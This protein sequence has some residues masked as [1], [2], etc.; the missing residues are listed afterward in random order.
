MVTIFTPTY[1]RK[2][3][4]KNLYK[5]LLKQTNNDFEWLIVDDGSIDKTEEEIN[6]LIKLNKINIR[7]L[8]KENGGKQSAYNIGLKNAKG[9]IFFCLDSDELLNPKAIEIIKNDFKKLDEDIAGVTYNRAYITNKEKVIGCKFPENIDKAY[10]YDI[11][12][13]LNVTG[14]KL[15]VFKYNIAKKYPFPHFEG[16]KF[17][18]EELIYNRIALKYM[19]KLSNEILSYTE[20]LPGGYSDNYFA[21]VKRNPKGNTLVFREKYDIKPT[22]YNV[23]GYIL[24]SIYSKYK[25]SKTLKDHPAKFKVIL[26]YI[27]TL[28]VS[29]IKGRKK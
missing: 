8:Y 17:V 26:L 4:L 23:Y 7:Y 3:E 28:F 13:K 5:S 10:Y 21:L 2:N 25:F 9:D 16:E 18:A 14:D 20:Y 1:N 6:K 12:G 15:M 27:P 11:Y 19:L 24:F 29:F 22:L